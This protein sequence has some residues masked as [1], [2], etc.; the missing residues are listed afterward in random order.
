V[1][2]IGSACFSYCESL[3]SLYL[4]SLTGVDEDQWGQ[5]FSHCFVL[6]KVYLPSYTGAIC[7]NAFNSDRALVTLILG[8]D[9]VCPL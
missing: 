1:A 7:T 9:T 2:H 8:A 6:K 3:E 4:P 5:N